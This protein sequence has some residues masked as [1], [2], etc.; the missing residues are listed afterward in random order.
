M[1]IYTKTGDKGQT[2][3]LSGKRVSKNY[4]R[5]E[6]YGTIDELNS[7]VGLIRSFDIDETTKGNL[8]FI[9]NCLFSI[10]SCLATDEK[11]HN[12]KNS[13]IS[14]KDIEFLEKEMDK[15]EEQLPKMK[16]FILPGGHQTVAITHICR[17]V[18]RRA[19]R[20]IVEL[21]EKEKIEDVI[22]M[23]INRLSDY[24]FMLSRKF[25]K[26]FNVEEV[27]WNSER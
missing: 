5:I 10:G 21:S 4:I 15:I 3:L 7:F 18:C 25:M 9:Q 20:I 11:K 22:I 27:T 6:A 24:F 26:D 19:E 12:L 14:E 2:S 1:K 17:T 8:I 23:F 16:N 13:E